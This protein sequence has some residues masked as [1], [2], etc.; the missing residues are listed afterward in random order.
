MRIGSPRYA[1][2]SGVLGVIEEAVYEETHLQMLPGDTLVLYTDGITEA[3]NAQQ[4]MFGVNR[5]ETV[6]RNT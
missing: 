3:H 2:N 1:G 4:Q 6:C 5:L